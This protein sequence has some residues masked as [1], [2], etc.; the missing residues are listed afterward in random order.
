MKITLLVIQSLFG[1]GNTYYQ[2]ESNSFWS[3]MFISFFGAFAG[4]GLSLIFYSHQIKKTK[5]KETHEKQIRDKNLLRYYNELI[6][7]HLAVAEKNLE[8]LQE[9]IIA[10]E[11]DLPNIQIVKRQPSYDFQRLLALD[12]SGVFE[13]WNNIFADENKIKRYQSANSSIDSLEA[14]IAEVHSMNKYVVE[15]CYIGLSEVKDSVNDLPDK[16]TLISFRI[17]NELGKDRN[18]DPLFMTIDANLKVYR[19]LTLEGAPLSIFMAEFVEPLL[20]SMNNDFPNHPDSPDIMMIC[21]KSRVK[22]NEMQTEIQRLV[23]NFKTV[24][25][26]VDPFLKTLRQTI[27]SLNA[28]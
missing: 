24:Q 20:I 28:I 23:D 2:N 7:K 25:P 27:I 10:Q 21:K 8:L 5:I 4:F 14:V 16:L 12:N 18:K 17:A 3:D 6:R 11:N 13:A 1:F 22:F 26:K 15:V 9:Y 19:K